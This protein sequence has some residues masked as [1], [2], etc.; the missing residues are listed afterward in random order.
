MASPQLVNPIKTIDPVDAMR[1]L[2]GD[3]EGL[4]DRLGLKQKSRGLQQRLRA[5]H[6]RVFGPRTAILLLSESATLKRRFLERLLGPLPTGVPEPR[7]GCLRLE[8][9]AE[10]EYSAAMPQGM[11][12]SMP[13][14]QLP[15]FLSRRGGEMTP[16]WRQTVRVPSPVLA[17]ELAVIDTP[18]LDDH[19]GDD[20]TDPGSVLE[21]SGWLREAAEQ[22]DCWV[23][24]MQAGSGLSERSIAALRQLPHEAGHLDIVAEGAERLGGDARQAAR[25]QLLQMLE[26]RC[27]LK[28]PRVTLLASA[29]AEGEVGSFWHGRFASFQSVMLMRG[30][31][32]WLERT[33]ELIAEALDEVGEEIHFELEGADLGMRPARLR[34][35][36]KDLDVLRARLKELAL[37]IQPQARPTPSLV[38]AVLWPEGTAPIETSP[39]RTAPEEAPIAVRETPAVL[40]VAAEAV[41]P[42]R[43]ER[44][45]ANATG[46]GYA[47]A[48][49]A[50]VSDPPVGAE[51]ERELAA[52]D[53]LI[54]S[55]WSAV[56]SGAPALA[57][58]AHPEQLDV[59][60]SAEATET[61]GTPNTPLL[62]SRAAAERPVAAE[63]PI[64]VES[65][66]V[67]A[68]RSFALSAGSLLAR[69]Q[70]FF[71]GLAAHPREVR[72]PS[73][74]RLAGVALLSAALWLIV[75]SVWPRHNGYVK[76]PAAQWSPSEL[77][78][79]AEAAPPPAVA[80]TTPA[81]HTLRPRHH[82]DGL[83]AD[84][85][86]TDLGLKPKPHAR[87]ATPATASAAAA[88][89]PAAKP[90]A[91]ERTALPQLAEQAPVRE[92]ASTSSK[93][94]PRHSFLGLG[95]VWHWVHR[96]DPEAHYTDTHA[97]RLQ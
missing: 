31:E 62:P 81:S 4:A 77:E 71:A 3:L 87:V 78:Q 68:H 43:E 85:S 20:W 45:A 90:S 72:L 8:H 64:V 89:E 94:Q 96:D 32:R 53:R 22:T 55:L 76:E 23:F 73:K 11:T 16:H 48:S 36:A 29:A 44:P 66:G 26:T 12:A 50:H 93:A 27:G 63:R 92:D 21:T 37:L 15:H 82:G 18:A 49:P 67:P 56:A 88:A 65:P 74:W 25:E 75:W 17:K 9:G 40:P 52:D 28:A 33:R 61:S 69:G 10:A 79:P 57:M 14:E 7:A 97:S 51:P 39:V 42:A 60:Y 34:L 30:R 46:L 1:L 58:G 6:E 83:V 41:L 24:V 35:G 5:T 91:A 95:K 80:S 2:V 59:E 54:A 38:P 86:F 47:M 70:R 19:F 84:P 13:L